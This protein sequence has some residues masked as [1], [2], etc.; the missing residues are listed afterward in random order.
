MYKKVSEYL[1][2]DI[3]PFH[4]PGHKRNANF[5]PPFPPG[6]AALD[7]TEIPEM[8]V[9]SSP[10]GIIKEFQEKI[11]DFYGA[12]RSFFLVNGTSAGIVAAVCAFAACGENIFGENKE[13][14]VFVPRNAHVSLYNGLIFS[15]ARP[16]YFL[17]EITSCGLAGGVSPSFFDSLPRGAAVFIVSPTYEGFVSDIAAIAQKVHARSGVL[18]VDEAHGAHFSFHKYFPKSALSQ[19]ADIVINSFHKTL[20][21]FS[22]CAVL[23]VRQG[24]DL[25]RLRFYINAMQTS[26]PSYMMMAACDF[27][28]E[29]LWESPDLFEE[30]VLRLEDIRRELPGAAE[31]AALRLYGRE[32]VGE[33]AIYDID[34][35]KLLFHSSLAAEEASDIMAR[36]YKV[37][38]EMAKGRHLLAMTSVADTKE[39]FTCLKAAVSGLNEKFAPSYTFA[40][41]MR[42]HELPEAVLT[43][44]EAMLQKSE[45][46]PREKAIGRISAELIVDYPPGIALVA[47]GERICERVTKPYVRVVQK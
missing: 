10:E 15:G 44:R 35:G 13:T 36:K 46:L 8:D 40:T 5:L 6:L 9:L 39:G 4:M 19:G 42:S 37:Q 14:P 32:R 30:Y 41:Q 1:S 24:L 29:K 34:E 22:G 33:G 7:L 23:H 47:P 20:P 25:P 18:I 11:A 27:M 3:Y 38:L 21:A 17:P 12:G 16:T 28:L 43:P 31:S 2:R 26:S 45:E